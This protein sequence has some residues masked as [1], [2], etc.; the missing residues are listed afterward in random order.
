MRTLTKGLRHWKDGNFGG[1]YFFKNTVESGK[2]KL[3]HTL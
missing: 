3:S 2:T 1:D